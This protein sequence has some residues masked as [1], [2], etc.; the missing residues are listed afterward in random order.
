MVGLGVSGKRGWKGL[1]LFDKSIGCS[2]KTLALFA[3]SAC[4][5]GTPPV[6]PRAVTPRTRAVLGV[7]RPRLGHRFCFGPR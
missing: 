5:S 3:R 1:S 6:L 2:D 7:V 4:P